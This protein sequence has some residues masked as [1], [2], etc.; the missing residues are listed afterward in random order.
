M[1]DPQRPQPAD[2]ENLKL[3][4]VEARAAELLLRLFEVP[5]YIAPTPSQVVWALITDFPYIGPHIGYTLIELFVGF[6]IGASGHQPRLHRRVLI[7]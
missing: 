5:A 6:A 4:R 7:P 1:D 2:P 3:D